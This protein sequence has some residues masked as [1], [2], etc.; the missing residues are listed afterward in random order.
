M[1]RGNQNGQ[2]RTLI[3][4]DRIL[5]IAGCS[6]TGGSEIDGSQDSAYNRENSYGGVLAGLL[7]R[8]PI[9]IAM[10]AM[11]NRAI[12]R[13]VLNWFDTEY[14][15]DTMDV[16][17]L[18]GWTE[19]IRIDFP[20]PH[21]IG[22]GPA[23]THTDYYTEINEHFLQINAGW[24]GGNDY[25]RGVIP[26]WHEYQARHEYMCELECIN[27]V[28]QMQYFCNS[29][30]V[31]YVMTNTMKMFSPENKHLDFYIGQVDQTK[32][33]DMLDNDAAFFWHYRN[34]GYENPKAKYW[35]H[36]EVPHKLHAE[37]LFRFINS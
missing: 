26:Y 15:A 29:K 18:I 33:M 5:L 2:T 17:V 28:L 3:M 10:V 12:A 22:Y 19:N 16:M 8:R 30:N 27:T 36:N 7:D 6:H 37:K 31:D 9:N 13:S 11:S 35:H 21:A 14:N 24:A 1:Y 4:S 23:N 32:Y 25:E 20:N 34:A